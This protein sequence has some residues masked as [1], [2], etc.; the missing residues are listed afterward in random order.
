MSGKIDT[1]QTPSE[2]ISKPIRTVDFGTDLGYPIRSNMLHKDVHHVF[3][4]KEPGNANLITLK[5]DSTN[6]IN[7]FFIMAD[8]GE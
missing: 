3:Q 4:E 6:A 2:N 8:A 5:S 1:D 7:V